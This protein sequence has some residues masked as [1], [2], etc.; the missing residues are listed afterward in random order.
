MISSRFFLS[1]QGRGH[2]ELAKNLVHNIEI[3][4]FVQDDK[5]GEF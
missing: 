5:T 1:S 4:H 3:L 2:S